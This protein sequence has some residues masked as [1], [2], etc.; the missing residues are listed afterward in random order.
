MLLRVDE[1]TINGYRIPVPNENGFKRTKN[2]LWSSNTG[3]TASG[4]MVGDIKAVKYT[5][6]FSWKKLTA[7]E[8]ALLETAVGTVA[9]FPVSFPKEGTGEK[10]TKNF[11]AADMTY[12]TKKY[13]NGN[14]IYSDA[15]L[16][17]IEQ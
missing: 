2:K 6:E 13:E 11:Y 15:V 16:Q 7:A 1:I 12:G 14:E 17:I 5:L 8:V 3:R 4:K 10:L 9:F